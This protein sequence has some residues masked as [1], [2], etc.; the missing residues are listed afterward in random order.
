MFLQT[1]IDERILTKNRICV[2][3]SLRNLSEKGELGIQET[4]ILAWGQI[5]WYAH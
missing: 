2:L 3:D 1:G 4:C 5:A